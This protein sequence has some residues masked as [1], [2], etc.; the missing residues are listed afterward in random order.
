MHIEGK[1][2]YHNIFEPSYLQVESADGQ[3]ISFQPS[4]INKGYLP[5]LADF[6]DLDDIQA[7]RLSSGDGNISFQYM[8]HPLIGAIIIPPNSIMMEH[9]QRN[10]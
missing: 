10:R 9:A 3:R 1:T 4:D 2:N 7:Y 8:I 6:S 5:Q